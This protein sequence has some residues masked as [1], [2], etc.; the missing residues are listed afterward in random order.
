ML[1][2]RAW[3]LVKLGEVFCILAYKFEET[4]HRNSFLNLDLFLCCTSHLSL[5]RELERERERERE[6]ETERKER[7]EKEGRGM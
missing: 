2:N 3:D 4:I 6:R 7:R 5:F 1:I